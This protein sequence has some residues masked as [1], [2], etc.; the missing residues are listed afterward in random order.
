V[1]NPNFCQRVVP[2]GYR[3]KVS[4]WPEVRAELLRLR[5][6]EPD[7]LMGY[8]DPHSDPEPAP[9]YPIS[10]NTQGLE[11]ARELH[12][13]FADQ[14]KLRV[15]ALPFPPGPDE[16]WYEPTLSDPL[17]LDHQL[18]GIRVELDGPLKVR[19]GETANH[20]LLVTNEGPA[21]FTVHTNG[22]L[23]ARII[24]MRDGS[25]VGGFAGAQRMPLVTFPVAPGQTV[26]IPLL[27]GTASFVQELGY[28]IAPG[29]W[30]ISVSLHFGDRSAKKRTPALPF[31]VT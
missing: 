5:D 3:G 24:D 12:E 22:T 9:P 2:Q 21:A 1:E 8:Q 15:G 13:R 23:T 29:R 17:P 19:S 20:A 11:V 30:G 26:S 28:S 4:S 16:P 7:V 25:H 31:E 14:V 10:L 27:V 6:V 18:A